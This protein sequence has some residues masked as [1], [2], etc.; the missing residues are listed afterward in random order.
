MKDRVHRK[1]APQ[2]RDLK[3]NLLSPTL[4]HVIEKDGRGRATLCRIR[5]DDET[6][7]LQE[8]QKDAPDKPVEFLVV[9]MTGPQCRGP[10]GTRSVSVDPTDAPSVAELK[11]L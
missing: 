9:F 6:I 1:G 3:G 10:V 11:K 8:I 2:V 5:Y 4:L 7:D